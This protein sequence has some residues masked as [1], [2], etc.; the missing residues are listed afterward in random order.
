MNCTVW[1]CEHCGKQ[2]H[3]CDDRCKECGQAYGSLSKIKEPEIKSCESE[4]DKLL[5]RYDGRD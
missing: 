5:K 1:T 3:I 2:N 4:S